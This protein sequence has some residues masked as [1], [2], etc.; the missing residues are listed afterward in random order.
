MRLI[1]KKKNGGFTMET[2]VLTGAAALMLLVSAG[3]GDVLVYTGEGT[4]SQGYSKFGT[5]TG[6]AVVYQDHLM[7]D[8][9]GYECIVLP[10]NGREYSADTLNALGVYVNAGGR[11]IA[12]ADHNGT[13]FGIAA[14]NAK[15]TLATALGTDLSVWG[16]SIDPYS[17]HITAS[18]D[19][20]PFTTG[21]TSISYNATSEVQV[22]AGSDAQSLVRTIGGTTFIAVDKVGDGMFALLGDMNVLS[23]AS[24]GY[25]AADNGVLAANLCGETTP[26]PE[27]I[28]VAIDIKF[29]SDPNAFNCKKKGVL[30]VTIFGTDSFDVAS[31]DV[32]TL[33][34]C[35]ED[36]SACTN[37][38]GVSSMADRGDP[39][40]DLGAAQCA[41]LEVDGIFEEQD[42]L[43][44]DGYY[45]LDVGFDAG[46]VQDMLGSFC[47]AERN[48]LSETLVIRGSTF[49]GT[50]FSSVPV[51]NTGID[52]LVKKH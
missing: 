47:G 15:N 24:N 12:E 28:E 32:S 6:K 39:T 13:P 19:P 51:G 23:D 18:I 26:V 3:A 27:G 16:D 31:I 50:P 2:K 30:P 20:S 11:I 5:A 1:Q 44:P 22:A 7:G 25:S 49:D 21:V 33:Q 52:Q 42:Y 9:S 43:N 37:A 48:A 4:S 29:C 41:M 36:F 45:D 35:T 38:P 46:E 40:S 10:P 8:L 17:F 34:L 14:I